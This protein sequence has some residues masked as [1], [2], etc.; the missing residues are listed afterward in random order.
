M[1][2]VERNVSAV[3]YVS[4]WHTRESGAVKSVTEQRNEGA[5]TRGEREKERERKGR[6]KEEK[7]NR[8]RQRLK[9]SRKKCKALNKRR[10]INKGK[11]RKK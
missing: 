8:L 7:K 11:E 6:G 9:R 1:L 10:R 4:G 2:C 5:A 3:V